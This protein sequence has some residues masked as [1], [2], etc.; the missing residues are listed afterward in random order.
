MIQNLNAELQ[1]EVHKDIYSKL[2]RKYK[3]FKTS[4]KSFVEEVALLVKE[5][6]IKP[7]EYI[8]K[9]GDVSDKLFFLLNGS[10]SVLLTPQGKK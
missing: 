5:K 6:K 1:C 2:L 8:F 4:S 3:L 7:E 9:Q 10:L